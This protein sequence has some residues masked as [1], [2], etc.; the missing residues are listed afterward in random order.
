MTDYL[1]RQLEAEKRLDEFHKHE[2][3]DRSHCLCEMLDTLIANHPVA[4]LVADEVTKAADALN[5]L[6]QSA[7]KLS[8]SSKDEVSK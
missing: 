4:H 1:N 3:L 5:A 6:Y 7:G 2:L 8:L